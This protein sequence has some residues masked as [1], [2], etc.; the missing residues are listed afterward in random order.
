MSNV[1]I[2][3]SLVSFPMTS[4]FF[5]EQ[6]DDYV[7]QFIFDE[8]QT[9]LALD[10]KAVIDMCVMNSDTFSINLVNQCSE[11]LG[12]DKAKKQVNHYI[13]IIYD[14][15]L[16]RDRKQINV[17]GWLINE[18][19]N[20]LYKYLGNDNNYLFEKYCELSKKTSVRH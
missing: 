18:D 2:A 19:N 1:I 9:K 16:I 10:C 15:L 7:S 14:Y 20:T 5:Y 17:N 4:L 3:N 8:E 6:R 12:E 11:F 13:S